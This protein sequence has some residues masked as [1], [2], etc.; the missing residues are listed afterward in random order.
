LISN[1][2]DNHG[3]LFGASNS[4]W[5]RLAVRSRIYKIGE[6]ELMWTLFLIL[7]AAIVIM[8]VIDNP[9]VEEENHKFYNKYY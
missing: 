9:K 2:G 4:P 8:A 5:N 7:G 1:K 3:V 6:R